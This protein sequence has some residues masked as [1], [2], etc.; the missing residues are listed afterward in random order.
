[1]SWRIAAATVLA[2]LLLGGFAFG[3]EEQDKRLEDIEERVTRLED[4]DDARDEAIDD[5]AEQ[6]GLG[7]NI[8]LQNGNVRGTVQIFGDVG[9]VYANPE[10]AGRG[11]AFF[12]NGSFDLF[13]RA[14]VGDHFHVLTET[15]F[16]TKVGSGTTGDSS[17]FDQERLW[18]AWD[19]SDAVRIKFGLEHSPISLWARTFHHGRWLEL[20]ISRPILAAFEAGSG[21]LPMHEAGVELMGDLPMGSG[22]FSYI[23]FVSNGRGA[24]ITQVQEFSDQNDDKAIMLGGSYRFDSPDTIV[25]G[26][27]ARTDELPADT[28]DPARLRPIREWIISLQ[29]K[30]QSDRIDVLSEFAFISDNDRASGRTFESYTGYIQFG[31]HLD[32]EFTPFI[33]IDFREMDQGNPYYMPAGR[34]LDAIQVVVGVR[35]NA[36]NNVAVTIE[37]VYGDRELRDGAGVVTTHGYTR[38]SIQLAFV[39]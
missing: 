21:I 29:I 20:T 23:V 28:T 2:V 36:L 35:Y 25:I 18:G 3:E 17:R 19:F 5:Y 1:M 13:F 6:A 15:V 37:V 14:R 33:R 7:L 22:T 9:A 30:V 31:V 12:F 8:V 4:G 10:T 39:F 16:L 32:D 26:L 34:D 24:K 11:N 27:F 38:V